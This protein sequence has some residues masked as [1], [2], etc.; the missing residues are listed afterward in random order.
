MLHSLVCK[1][2]RVAF[3]AH[4][5]F[6][7]ETSVDAGVPYLEKGKEKFSA[8]FIAFRNT[9]TFI[10]VMFSRNHYFPASAQIDLFTAPREASIASIPHLVAT[11]MHAADLAL[12]LRVRQTL[13]IFWH[14]VSQDKETRRTAIP[15]RSMNAH[16]GR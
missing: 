7:F 8:F 10:A 4:T 15:K 13:Q 16:L 6:L 3:D 12:L 11:R 9:S 5:F 1:H 2:A 14:F